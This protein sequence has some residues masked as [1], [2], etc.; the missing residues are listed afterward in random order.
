M[1]EV[2]GRADAGLFQHPAFGQ[3]AAGADSGLKDWRRRTPLLSR[4]GWGEGSNVEDLGEFQ[5][6]PLALPLGPLPQGEGV[7]FL[8]FTHPFLFAASRTPPRSHAAPPDGGRRAALRTSLR[9]PRARSGCRNAAGRA[10]DP[11]SVT[12]GSQRGSTGSTYSRSRGASGQMPRI[13]CS[14]ANAEPAAQ[15]CGTLAPRYCTGNAALAAFDAGVQ[16]GQLVQQEMA[17]RL[18]RCRARSARPRRRSHS[19]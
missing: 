1:I 5:L 4:E 17:G 16:L 3:F 14:S 6:L 9:R 8:S 11:T 12:S 13:A 7:S 18:A 2:M 10:A 19:A 15:A